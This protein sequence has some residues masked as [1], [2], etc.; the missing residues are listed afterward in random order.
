MESTIALNLIKTQQLNAFRKAYYIISADPSYPVPLP[1]R[2][3]RNIKYASLDVSAVTRKNIN[4]L[5]PY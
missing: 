1:L 5:L 3:N 2:K 4:T